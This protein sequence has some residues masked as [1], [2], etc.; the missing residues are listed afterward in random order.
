MQAQRVWRADVRIL[1]RLRTLSDVE[2]PT[3]R[4]SAVSSLALAPLCWMS[5][6]WRALSVYNGHLERRPF[7]VNGLTAGVLAGVGDCAAQQLESILEIQSI[8]KEGY[9]YPRTGRMIAWGLFSGS[10]M[11]YPWLIWLD[12]AAKGLGY[13]V[14]WRMIGFKLF[15]DQVLCMPLFVKAYLTLTSVLEGKHWPA[16]K[17]KVQ[18][19]VRLAPLQPAT[20][21]CKF[22][23]CRNVESSPEFN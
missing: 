11:N 19:K 3:R 5:I 16:I 2:V 7:I 10:C 23:L 4:Y 6:F 8:G 9:N 22:V 13:G 18:A 12:H 1:K 20:E 14:G 17:A 21:R 15:F